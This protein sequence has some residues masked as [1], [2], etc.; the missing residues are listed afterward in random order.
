MAAFPAYCDP[1]VKLD[2]IRYYEDDEDY[3]AL[4]S[5]GERPEPINQ[6]LYYDNGTF[7]RSLGGDNDPR[8]FWAIRFEAE[9]LV[10]YVGTH[11]R[12]VLLYDVGAGTYQLW[13]YIRGDTAP[14]N[15][16]RSQNMALT[17]AQAW[18]EEI[19]SPA[20][21]IPENEPL[22]IVVGQQGLSRPAAACQDMGN[23]NG[24]WVSLNGETW[25]DMHITCTILGCCV[26]LS[27][28]RR[29]IPRS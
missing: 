15:L 6:W 27:P 24:R 19:I 9:D 3:G 1:P 12:K 17:N 21:E 4:V 2:G 8:I 29:G 13:I 5:W 7:K 20:Y 16:V 26:P 11:L 10:D 18:H 28:T 22:W 14:R 25:T 23:P